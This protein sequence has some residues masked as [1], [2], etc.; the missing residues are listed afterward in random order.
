[1][2]DT[3]TKPDTREDGAPDTAAE[4]AANPAA[5][6]MPEFTESTES[7]ESAGSAGSAESTGAMDS[8]EETPLDPNA[9]YLNPV[10]PQ[11]RRRSLILPPKVKPPSRA[12]I[13]INKGVVRANVWIYRKTKGRVLGKFGGIDALLITTQGRKTGKIRTNPV[14][15]IWDRGRFVVVAAYGGEAVHPAWYR[16]LRAVPKVTVNIGMEIIDCTARTEP[17]GPERE[18]IWAELVKAFPNYETFQHRTDRLLPVVVLTPND[19]MR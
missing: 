12:S 6:A 10:P 14:G 11:Q 19:L 2:T 16:N 7:T 17:P 13:L 15:Y 5:D 3:T 8:A 9:D 4:S 18:R 1:M